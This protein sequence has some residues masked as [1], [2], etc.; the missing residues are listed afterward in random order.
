MEHLERAMGI[1]GLVVFSASAD[2]HGFF[3]DTVDCYK[4]EIY[5]NLVYPLVN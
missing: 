3:L 4:S 5:R 2:K 1:N